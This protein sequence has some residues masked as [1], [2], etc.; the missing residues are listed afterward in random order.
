MGQRSRFK[1]IRKCFELNEIKVQHTK[2]QREILIPLFPPILH[3]TKITLAPLADVKIL[4][5][6]GSTPFFL[7][8]HSISV[9]RSSL[10]Q[11]YN[12]P[13]NFS[14]LEASYTIS[15]RVTSISCLAIAML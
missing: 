11:R 7:H 8:M 2:N 15:S 9:R 1:E 14:S 6:L 10:F 5:S 12:S 13:P 4:I 3:L